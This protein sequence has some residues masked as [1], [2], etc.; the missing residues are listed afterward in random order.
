MAEATPHHVDA[1]A[2]EVRAQHAHRHSNC[3][4]APVL[5][6][7][8]LPPTDERMAAPANWRRRTCSSLER[9]MNGCSVPQCPAVVGNAPG[10]GW[11]PPLPRARSQSP[12]SDFS[13]R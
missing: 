13:A 6:R 2:K 4:T 7:P 5:R 8:D 1:E 10:S 9:M 3:P 12:Q 11:P